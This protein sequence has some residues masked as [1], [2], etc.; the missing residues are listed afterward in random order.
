MITVLITVFALLLINRDESPECKVEVELCNVEVSLCS[1]TV[2][3]NQQTG[4]RFDIQYRVSHQVEASEKIGFQI[5]YSKE[6]RELLGRDRSGITYVQIDKQQNPVPLNTTFEVY[7]SKL[8]NNTDF[9]KVD[10]VV[11]CYCG[12]RIFASESREAVLLQ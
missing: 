11:H 12:D 9:E 6:L 7:T 2:G 3:N 8:F 4:F 10:F 5:E 1:I